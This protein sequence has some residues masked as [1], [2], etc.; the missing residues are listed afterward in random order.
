MIIIGT[1]IGYTK[2]RYLSD[3]GGLGY[4]KSDYIYIY[5]SAYFILNGV[6]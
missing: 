4:E 2:M 6:W 5:R 3:I 1:I